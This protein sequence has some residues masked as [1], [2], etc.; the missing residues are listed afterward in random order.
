MY[1][2]HM[3]FEQRVVVSPP[4]HFFL[5]TYL[6]MDE[7]TLVF[8]QIYNQYPIMATWKHVF[9]NVCKFIQIQ[10]LKYLI[11]KKRISALWS[12]TSSFLGQV[13][14]S[15]AHLE[16][17]TCSELHQTAVFMNIVPP[18]LMQWLVIYMTNNLHAQCCVWPSP[19]FFT[20]WIWSDWANKNENWLNI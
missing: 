14:A 13:S 15:S 7:V 16:L 5:L 4:P 1:S 3:K 18:A 2:V 19:A 11:Y 9:R 12:T 6:K 20:Y 10:T 17:G 8:T